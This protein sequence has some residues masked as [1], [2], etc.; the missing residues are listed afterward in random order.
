MHRIINTFRF[1]N[2]DLDEICERINK[3]G[4]DFEADI[5]KNKKYR[6]FTQ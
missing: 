6:N 5:I 4:E 3:V 1:T 2:S